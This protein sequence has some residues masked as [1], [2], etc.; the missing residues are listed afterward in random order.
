MDTIKEKIIDD[1]LSSTEFEKRFYRR[2]ELYNN[3]LEIIPQRYEDICGSQDK[4]IHWLAFRLATFSNELVFKRLDLLIGESKKING[5]SNEF[6]DRGVEFMRDYAKFFQELWMLQ[7]AEYLNNPER[8]ISFYGKKG[9]NGKAAPDIMIQQGDRTKYVECYVYSKWWFDENCLEEI[10]QLINPNFFIKRKH[11]LKAINAKKSIDSLYLFIN[12]IFKT[13][14]IKKAQI[15]ADK[16]SPFIFDFKSD[17]FALGLSGKGQYSPGENAHGEPILS[18]PVFLREI[19]SKKN[20]SNDLKNHHP[21]ILMVNG[22]GYDYKAMLSEIDDSKVEKNIDRLPH[23]HKN[24]IDQLML[25]A[26][27]I[28]QKM[29][30]NKERIFSIIN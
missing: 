15:E 22:L 23:E 1:I 9:K 13:D 3:I 27:D 26:C 20:N 7:C 28:D 8:T 2:K 16:S 25:T 4:R 24:N 6:R 14:K 21:N 18:A 5:W 12:S 11:N 29:S 17:L 10:I 30:E 19:L